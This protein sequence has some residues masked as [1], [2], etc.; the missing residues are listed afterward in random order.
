MCPLF[1]VGRVEH[2]K[3]NLTMISSMLL[4]LPTPAPIYILTTEGLC[5]ASINVPPLGVLVVRG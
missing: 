2:E 3:E 4:L 1:I 5:H